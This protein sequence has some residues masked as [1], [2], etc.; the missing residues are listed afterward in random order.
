MA[1]DKRNLFINFSGGVDSG[2]DPK[3]VIPSKFTKLDDLEFDRLQT[4]RQRPGY[5]KSTIT[6]HTDS[7]AVSS[8]QHLHVLGAEL[9]LEAASGLHAFAQNRTVNK[10]TRNSFGNVKTFERGRIDYLPVAASS[11]TQFSVDA[12]TASPSGLECWAWNEENTGGKVALYYQIVDSATR[13]V[14]QQGLVEGQLTA[15]AGT[16]AFE[17]RVLVRNSA[18][19]STFYIYYSKTHTVGAVLSLEMKSIAVASGSKAPGA[20]SGASVISAVAPRGFD[21]WY[22]STSDKVILAY[23]TTAVAGFTLS[24]LNGSN[25]TTVSSTVNVVADFRAISVTAVYNGATGR[26]LVAYDDRNQS[27]LALPFDAQTVNFTSGQVLTGGTSGATATITAVS[28]GGTAGYLSLTPIAGAFQNDEGITDALGGA[29][30]AASTVHARIMTYSALLTGGTPITGAVTAS[31]GVNEGLPPDGRLCVAPSPFASATA[32]IFYD[33]QYLALGFDPIFKTD[34][35]YVQCSF[36]GSTP[37]LKSVFARGVSLASR[38]IS[39]SNQGTVAACVGAAL[40]SNVQPTLFLLTVDAGCAI[41]TGFG[42]VNLKTHSP[43]KVLARILP[44][45]FALSTVGNTVPPRVVSTTRL[46]CGM[47]IV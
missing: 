6:A 21:G 23:R 36:D 42:T 20:L 10:E 27:P 14:L 47:A 37:T 11:N 7:T 8:I 22:D 38:L 24:I 15:A 2:R 41:S 29:A 3:T 5:T 16:E 44:G 30:T 13:A 33:S 46:L 12:A 18:G 4:M 43:P 39:Y 35:S 25:G 26:A 45:E 1:L 17:P 19:A 34:I 28:D 31:P 32:V 9:I 40:L